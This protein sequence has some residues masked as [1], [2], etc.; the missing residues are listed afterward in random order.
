MPLTLAALATTH[1]TQILALGEMGML[2]IPVTIAV[3]QSRPVVLLSCQESCHMWHQIWN[4]A[5]L[6]WL[7]TIEQHILNSLDA[8]KCAEELYYPLGDQDLSLKSI[9]KLLV[10]CMILPDID[11]CVHMFLFGLI[12]L[13]NGKFLQIFGLQGPQGR[14]FPYSV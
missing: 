4:P 13:L 2:W 7:P 10:Q 8:L 6:L 3:R 1:L 9:A 11:G 12:P 5:S 14:S